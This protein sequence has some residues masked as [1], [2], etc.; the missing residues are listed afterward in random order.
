[1]K[2]V[3]LNISVAVALLTAIVNVT[4]T[5]AS[6]EET[7]FTLEDSIKNQI[8]LELKANVENL[9][10]NGSLPVPG[11]DTALAARVVS[12]DENREFVLPVNMDAGTVAKDKI[13]EN[14]N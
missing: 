13:V 3:K 9:Y 4:S 2:F 7:G 1:M 14:I 8:F 5:S 10:Q 6:A 11:I 12:N